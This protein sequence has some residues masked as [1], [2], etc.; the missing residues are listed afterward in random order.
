MSHRVHCESRENLLQMEM[1]YSVETG[2][3][4]YEDKGQTLLPHVT[5]KCAYLWSDL[6]FL[7]KSQQWFDKHHIYMKQSKESHRNKYDF[8]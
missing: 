2:I 8:Y 4:V 3:I 1:K 5:N 7:I 6:V